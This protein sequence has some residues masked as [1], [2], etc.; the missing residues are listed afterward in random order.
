MDVLNTASLP[1][2]L[3]RY[4]VGLTQN[5]QVVLS[6]TTQNDFDQLVQP[7]KEATN[8]GKKFLFRS[9]ASLLTSFANL[10]AQPVPAEKVASYRQ[11]TKPGIIFAGSYVQNTTDQLTELL[12]LENVRGIEI[13]LDA[14]QIPSRRRE[15]VNAIAQQINILFSKKITPVVFTPRGFQE[16]SNRQKQ[17]Q[18]GNNINQFFSELAAQLPPDLG[19]I[20]SKGGNTTNQ[21]LNKGLNLNKAFLLGQ[22]LPGC[23]LVKA[24]MHHRF[25]ALPIVLFPGN[26][27]DR[28]SL[29]TA[30]QRLEK[31]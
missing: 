24:P 31:P 16:Q 1:Q 20:I 3:D 4:L 14:C 30:F 15:Q 12:S 19:Y 8:Q 25:P 9:A 10:G 17:I 2:N 6:G 29:I 23:C 27:G 11:S 13:D 18:F 21:L 22:I 7:L 5:K 28:H 26:V